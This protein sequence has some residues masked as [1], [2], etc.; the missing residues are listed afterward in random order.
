M[1]AWGPWKTKKVPKLICDQEKQRLR[2]LDCEVKDE[3]PDCSFDTTKC[4]ITY[5]VPR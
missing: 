4:L 1:S 5:R 2:K 3:C